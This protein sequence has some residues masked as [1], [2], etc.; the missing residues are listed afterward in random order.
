M[1]RFWDTVT[2][3]PSAEGY[4]ILLDGK[5]MHLP[6]GA[7]LRVGAEPLARAIA[8]EWQ[9]AGGE[10]GGRSFLSPREWKSGK[11]EES[12]NPFPFIYGGPGGGSRAV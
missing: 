3:E 1:K 12:G 11:P 9:I 6:G 5:K 10:K 7:V 2:I 4:A 8:D